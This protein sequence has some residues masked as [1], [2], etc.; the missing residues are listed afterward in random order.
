MTDSERRLLRSL[1]LHQCMKLIETWCEDSSPPPTSSNPPQ[2]T[3]FNFLSVILRLQGDPIIPMALL[4]GSR[5]N[6]I[7]KAVF[8][9]WPMRSAS[10]VSFLDA[11]GLVEIVNWLSVSA[12]LDLAITLVAYMVDAVSNFFGDSA[13]PFGSLNQCPRQISALQNALSAFLTNWYMEQMCV[14][15]EEAVSRVVFKK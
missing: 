13:E 1:L 6:P 5:S 3:F 8:Q 7:S 15:R 4:L 12:R 9:M 2:D 10:D 14:H 11:F